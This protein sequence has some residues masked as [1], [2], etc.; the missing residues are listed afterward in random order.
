MKVI[1]LKDVRALGRKDDIKDVSDG[2]ARNFLLPRGLAQAATETQVTGARQRKIARAHEAETTLKAAQE[3]VKK[4]D[5]YELEMPVKA[6]R[7]GT[8]YAAVGIEEIRT[9]LEKKGIGIGEASIKN[10]TH[11]KEVG[12]HAVTL[13]FPHNLEAVI[14]VMLAKYEK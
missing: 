12:E 6:S 9:A 14:R 10:N 8:L 11:L 2:Y 13:Q 1:L 3:L 7:E 4:L 5:G